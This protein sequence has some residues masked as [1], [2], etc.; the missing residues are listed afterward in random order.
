MNAVLKEAVLFLLDHAAKHAYGADADRAT[1]LK[2]AVSAVQESQ[3]FILHFKA[4]APD[5]EE[6]IEPLPADY[7]AA[8]H[9]EPPSDFEP[10]PADSAW[11][12]RATFLEPQQGSEGA[13]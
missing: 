2:E 11:P 6:V 8:G 7:I 12:H 10:P 3:H 4:A 5:A 1:E 13:D 9:P